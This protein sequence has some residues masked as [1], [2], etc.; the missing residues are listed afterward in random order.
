ML[1]KIL[2]TTALSALLVSPALAQDTTDPDAIDPPAME[3]TTPEQGTDPLLDS[4][5]MDDPLDD[6]ADPLEA[7]E[8]PLGAPETEAPE[9]DMPDMPEATDPGADVGGATV[10]ADDVIGADLVDFEG[11]SIATVDDVVMDTTGEIESV[12]VDVGGFLGFGARTVAIPLAD[13]T[14]DTDADGD[15]V[16]RTALSSDD[17]E[18]LPEYEAPEDMDD[19][20]MDGLGDPAADPATDDLGEPAT[21]M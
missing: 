3:E 4:E 18:N 8:D 19:P 14:I 10:M 11:N 7:P 17:L 2:A 12:L 13:I 15:T 6:P 9:T 21:E 5:P 16:L 20:A 1:K